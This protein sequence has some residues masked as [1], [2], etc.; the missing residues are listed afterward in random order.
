MTGGRKMIIR[1]IT[2]AL[3]LGMSLVTAYAI[4]VSAEEAKFEVRAASSMR[5]VLAEQTGKRVAIRLAA[6]EEIEG[7]VVMV[8]LSLVHLTKLSGKEFYDAVIR[9][10][11]IAGVRLRVR[12]R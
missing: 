11:N 7:T 1:V 2:A 3:W 6:G 8:G 5:D 10:D 4:N 9:I 12:D